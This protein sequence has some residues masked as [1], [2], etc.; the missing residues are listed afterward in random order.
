MSFTTYVVITYCNDNFS[1]CKKRKIML[2]V[3]MEMG[4]KISVCERKIFKIL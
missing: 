4:G 2:L 3:K 1:H